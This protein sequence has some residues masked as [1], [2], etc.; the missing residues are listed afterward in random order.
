MKCCTP[1]GRVVDEVG[2]QMQLTAMSVIMGYV[3]GLP[4]CYLTL[5]YALANL[6]MYVYETSHLITGKL[7]IT[8]GE[9]GPIET[10]SVV[11]FL[12]AIAGIFG[13]GALK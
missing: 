11:A 13:P 10:F 6:P 9:F 12:Y 5:G 8:T 1:L 2:D 4:P 7:M 3:V